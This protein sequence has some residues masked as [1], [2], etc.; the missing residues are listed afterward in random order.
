MHLSGPDARTGFGKV[1]AHQSVR[2]LR[3]PGTVTMSVSHQKRLELAS[4]GDVTADFRP[5]L[6]VETHSPVSLEITG[7]WKYPQ[8]DDLSRGTG[9]TTNVSSISKSNEPNLPGQIQEG[10][11]APQA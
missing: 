10:K 1:R 7:K 9:R 11:K 2:E 4:L 5:C 6:E 3:Q 8:S